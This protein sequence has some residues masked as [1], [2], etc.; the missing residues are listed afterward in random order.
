MLDWLTRL[1]G[2]RRASASLLGAFL[3]T[4]T[5]LLVTFTVQLSDL[6][7][8]W[9]K[10]Q[11]TAG[12]A[13]LAASVGASAPV[14]SSGAASASAVATALNVASVNGFGG[15]TVSTSGAASGGASTLTTTI[16]DTPSLI[17]GAWLSAAAP[18]I[19]APAQA[20]MTPVT[21]TDCAAS[22]GGGFQISGSA[23]ASGPAC[24]LA[25]Q[26]TIAMSGGSFSAAAAA[27]G[28]H[29]YDEIPLISGGSQSPA[30]RSFMFNA[31]TSDTAATNLSVI[32]LRAHLQSLATWPYGS[33]IPQTATA[34]AVPAGG[35]QVFGAQTVSVPANT[36]WG[37]LT[38][39]G[40]TL[41][42]AGSG[43]AD[44]SCASP[45]T[46]SGATQLNGSDT[47]NFGSGCYIFNGS[48]S[49]DAGGA[50]SVTNF[51]VNPGATV[52]FRFQST[53]NI[54]VASGGSL[55]IGSAYSYSFIGNINST[56][57]GTFSVGAGTKIFS[58]N[59]TIY[60]GYIN[61]GNGTSYLSGTTIFSG[62]NPSSGITFGNGP[63]Y[64]WNGMIDNVQ[65]GH[66]SFGTGPYYFFNSQIIDGTYGQGG[67][68]FAGGNYYFNGGSIVSGQNY[69]S[70]MNFTA[71]NMDLYGGASISVS[72][73]MRLG[74]GSQS[75]G[76]T[77]VSLY[78]G[79]VTVAAGTLYLSGGTIAMTTGAFTVSGGGLQSA[80]PTNAA[81]AY[82]Y[83]DIALL[84][85]GGNVNITGGS[86]S[87]GGLIYAPGG[88]VT[89]SGAAV[90][91]RIGS[92]CLSVIANSV[93]LSGSSST[94]MSPC[95]GL[96]A[97]T[98]GIAS[99]LNR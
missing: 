57:T 84:S 52:V 28:A 16:T 13:A 90:L 99:T 10:V 89:V 95:A 4:T 5:V 61:F 54:N 91:Q 79:S 44:D 98:T 21:M 48:V 50:S 36:H 87:V 94:S 30:V 56:S 63:F 29:A 6:Y 8:I 69:F 80:P 17:M 39:A 7:I 24:G 33:T 11:R 9:L 92:Y 78:G 42:F 93:A 27:V 19:A 43:G 18:V 70:S 34:Q 49:T 31:A 82:G 73:T 37:A 2:D 47:L 51:T 45:T 26:S 97:V 55:N 20:L 65:N 75:S 71:G 23:T 32:A 88:A 62:Y 58:G 25:S 85:T 67:V 22:L 77:T 12:L 3:I 72:S 14:V 83:T 76:S 64:L 81:P 46:V 60:N 40:S 41:N 96:S 59:I 74:N 15:S 1:G 68:N 86:S 38:L 66:A 53:V 35:P